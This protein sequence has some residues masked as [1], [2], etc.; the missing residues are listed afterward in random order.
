MDS[1][2]YCIECR[3]KDPIKTVEER[4]KQREHIP[5]RPRERTRGG[6]DWH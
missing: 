1:P 2:G 3:W 4:F 5:D 6:S